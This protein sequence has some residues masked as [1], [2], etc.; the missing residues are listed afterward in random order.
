MGGHKSLVPMS[1]SATFVPRL[2]FYFV[3]RTIIQWECDSHRSLQSITSTL[4]LLLLKTTESFFCIWRGHVPDPATDPWD[5]AVTLRTY[6]RE[7]MASHSNYFCSNCRKANKKFHSGVRFLSKK[8]HAR[9]GW[10]LSAAFGTSPKPPE[11]RFATPFMSSFTFW[12]HS[13]SADATVG[14]TYRC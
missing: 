4:L 11:I 7:D 12:G 2:H 3:V 5:V 14:K 13:I 10:Y 6:E 8:F 9:F 1:V